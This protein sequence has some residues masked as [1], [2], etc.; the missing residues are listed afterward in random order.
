MAAQPRKSLLTWKTLLAF[1]LG[2]ILFAVPAALISGRLFEEEPPP[3]FEEQLCALPEEWLLRVQ[4]GHKEGRS[5]DITMLPVEPAYFGSAAGGWS[6]SGPQPHLQEIPLV[7]Y[8]PGII[9]P[10]PP[11]DRP[12]T[13]A[14]VAPTTATLMKGSIASD[15]G[16]ALPE[17]ARL[18]ADSL[19]QPA[20]K[21]IVTV[22]LD[23]GGWN[24]LEQ[25]PGDWTNLLHMI[26]NGVSY[27]NATV[28]SSPSVTPA[29]HTTIGTGVFPA[30]HGITDIPV[31]DEDGTIFDAFDKGQSSRFIDVPTLAERWDEQTG[32]KALVGMIG[33]E[34]WH[35][36]MIGKG[37]EKPGG[38]KDDAVW[39]TTDTNEWTSSQFYTLPAAISTT[40]GL[41]EDIE[42][43]DA[44]DGEADGAWGEHAI[45]EDRSRWEET[46][47]FIRYHL[48]AMT[49]LVERKGYGSDA[50][51]DLL[52]TNFK[53]IDRVGHYF[54]M[55]SPEVNE[56]LL[57][58]DEVLGEFTGFLDDEVGTGNYVVIVTADH[59][60]QPDAPDINGYSIHTKELQADIEA[61]FGDIVEAFRPTTIFLDRAKLTEL[62][63]SIAE[64]ARWVGVYTVAQNS[65][66]GDAY[67]GSFEPG[68][69][70]LSLAVPTSELAGVSCGQGVES[71]GDGPTPD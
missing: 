58:T 60:Q 24:V 7:F 23:G 34:A 38:D 10:Q 14:D 5:G 39:L 22:V 65:T 15:D 56:S 41:E 64:V 53:Q 27:E 2:F 29:V 46:P 55:D 37:S 28:G 13:L 45:L 17:V 16:M 36:G 71:H 4:R 51:T 47:A 33:Y 19:E 9:E 59:G 66:G 8:G 25:L 26:E 42:R 69:K 57:V 6:H 63:L 1:L 21:L 31:R 12:V 70:V 43:L 67:T 61:E 44:E 62:G 18:D 30:T 50:V 49:N 32:N 20:P 40:G 54:N 48:R 52:Y 3:S 35:L 11:I 68:D